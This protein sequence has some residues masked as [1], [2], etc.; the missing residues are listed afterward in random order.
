[1]FC[2]FKF[3]RGIIVTVRLV[4]T[5]LL[6]SALIAVAVVTGALLA[7]A[8][9]ASAVKSDCP[10]GYVC[11]WSGPTYGGSAA[12]FQGSEL[13]VKSLANIDPRSAWNHTAN[14]IVGVTGGSFESVLWEGGSFDN[15]SSGYTGHIVINTSPFG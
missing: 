11:L 6:A 5:N 15:L 3:I 9:K 14:K 1:M 7:L 12:F 2:S 4:K 13:G 10:F 8:P